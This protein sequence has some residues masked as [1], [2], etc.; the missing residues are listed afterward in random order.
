MANLSLHTKMQ[1]SHNTVPSL[2]NKLRS[3]DSSKGLCLSQ[4]SWAGKEL[5][6]QGHI[7][8]PLH[9]PWRRNP[10]CIYICHCRFGGAF[11]SSWSPLRGHLYGGYSPDLAF[12]KVS[13][14]SR[15][16]NSPVTSSYYDSWK[17]IW[18]VCLTGLDSAAKSY[19]LSVNYTAH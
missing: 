4:I 9:A 10:H 8:Y 6:S 7:M 17:H 13:M 16:W 11:S 19:C 18:N 2:A 15:A 14:C 12:Q 5:P 3:Q 1:S